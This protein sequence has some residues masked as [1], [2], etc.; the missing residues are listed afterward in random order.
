MVARTTKK[1]N[2]FTGRQAAKL[3]EEHAEEQKQK[4]ETT[5][6][7][8]AK[9]EREFEDQILDMTEQPS[10]PTVVDEVIEVGVEMADESIVVRLAEDVEN[11]TYGH[12]NNYTFKA[13]GKYKVPVPVANRLQSLGLLYE[14]L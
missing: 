12:G 3:A 8:T 9:A 2:D 6:M 14:R 10:A 4:A 1:Q 13:G 5:A 11:M 7:M